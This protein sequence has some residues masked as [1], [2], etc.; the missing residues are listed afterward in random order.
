MDVQRIRAIFHNHGYEFL[1]QI[2]QGGFGTVFKAHSNKYQEEFCIKMAQYTQSAEM[3]VK[4]L[5]KLSH[6]NIISMYD[7]FVECGFLFIVLEYCPN[8]SLS[9]IIHANQVIAPN[10]LKTYMM[11]LVKAL[12]YCH[13]NNV[14]HRDI[15]PANVLVDKYGRLK[16]SDF[17]ISCVI[18]EKIKSNK[19]VGS[20]AYMPPEL[21]KGRCTDLFA[22]DVWSLGITFFV[23]AA[24]Y[25]PWPTDVPKH[26]IVNHILIGC[27]SFPYNLDPWITQL[28]RPMLEVNSKRRI[29]LSQLLE[30]LSPDEDE[31]LRTSRSGT[32]QIRSGP[33]LPSSM[34]TTRVNPF[35]GSIFL[36]DMSKICLKPQK[37]NIVNDLNCQQLH[38]LSNLPPLKRRL[39]STQFSKI[40]LLEA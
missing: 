7:Y 1:E 6:P 36:R 14:A 25:L 32:I 18:D 21:L 29:K 8:G 26:E 20:L 35:N 34:S 12:D 4:N 10:M 33:G 38:G 2:G 28:I 40:N 16:L 15:K 31:T 24:G 37:K 5:L 19:A 27:V 11:Q 3:E 9:S 39:T 23:M 22:A 13:E 17:G 30:S